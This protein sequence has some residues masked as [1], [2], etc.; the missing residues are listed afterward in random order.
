MSVCHL[1]VV[2]EEF[3][4]ATLQLQATCAFAITGAGFKQTLYC[5]SAAAG[6]LVSSCLN[7]RACAS[8][9]SRRLRLQLQRQGDSA[10]NA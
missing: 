8:R 1:A 3:C 2:N 5:I 7:Q 4:L 6:Q 10:C 9:T